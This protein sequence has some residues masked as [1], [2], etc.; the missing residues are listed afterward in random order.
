MRNG[1]YPRNNNIMSKDSS[2]T[3]SFLEEKSNALAITGTSGKILSPASKV[4]VDKT[5]EGVKKEL[6]KLTDI[7]HNASLHT[8]ECEKYK[9]NL[10]RMQCHRMETLNI[11]K[12]LN[13]IYN[14]CSKANGGRSRQMECRNRV[15]NYKT[16]LKEFI[17][18]K[19]EY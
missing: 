19:C 1:N 16:F 5:K 8:K 9:D 11:I 7:I 4:L 2:P 13:R 17:K 3:K 6:Y 18:K 12:D 14:S 15:M 10:V